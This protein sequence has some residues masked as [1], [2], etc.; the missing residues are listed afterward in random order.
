[1]LSKLWAR[2]RRPIVGFLIVVL[3]AAFATWRI[4]D[5]QRKVCQTVRSIIITVTEV[6]PIAQ[7]RLPASQLKELQAYYDDLRERLLPKTDA[8]C[9]R[10]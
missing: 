1:M 5:N 8:V 3:F 7:K 6:S 4:Y 10:S 2:L 9:G